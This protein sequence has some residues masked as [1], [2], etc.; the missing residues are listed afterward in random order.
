[1]I[2]DYI[3]FWDE[4]TD[5]NCKHD[6]EAVLMNILLILA[7]WLKKMTLFDKIYYK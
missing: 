1:M 4:W 7:K 2:I 6:H 5:Q 3:S